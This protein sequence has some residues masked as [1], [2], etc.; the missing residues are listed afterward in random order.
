M[1]AL[2]LLTSL[3][4]GH[5]LAGAG[6]GGVNHPRHQDAPTVVLISIDGFRWDFPERYPAQSLRRIAAEGAAAERLLPVW[7]TLTFPYHYTLATGLRPARHG[8]VSNDFPDP[9]TG[10][11]Y[12]LKDRS[13]VEDASFY[14]GEPVW[15]TAETQGMVTASFFWVGSEAPISGVRPTH[16]RRYDKQVPGEERVGQVLEWLAEPPQTRPHLVTLYFE[17]V[18]DH[19][20]WNGIG[21]ADFLDAV[22]RVD[23]WLGLLLDG[24]F[25]LPQ[26]VPLY[27]VLVSDHGQAPY[28]DLDA[29]VLDRWVDLDG[30]ALIDG[31]SYV[32]AWQERPDPARAESLADTVNAQW[33]HGRAWTRATAPASWE[34]AGNRRFPDLVFQADPGHAVLSTSERAGKISA[35]DHG[36]A[37]DDPAMHGI[38]MVRGPGIQPGTRLGAVRNVDVA[39]MI[40]RLL[41]LEPP[42][43]LDGDADTLFRALFLEQPAAGE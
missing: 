38:F 41:R 6:S 43:G 8:I 40:L 18:D 28:A 16:W 29:L 11:W 2:C 17:A 1:P 3:W 15:V 9:D 26:D 21:S 20:H 32:M 34:L 5:T 27:L 33:R 31:G 42:A 22:A 12:R 14:G 35:G 19:A 30:L 4:T 25:A 37:P 39:P 36:W 7:P 13:A 24:L 10:R 23:R